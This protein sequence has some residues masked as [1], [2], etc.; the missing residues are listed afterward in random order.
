MNRK[1]SIFEQISMN[2]RQLELMLNIR[3]KGRDEQERQYL[4]SGLYGNNAVSKATIGIYK[5]YERKHI[6]SWTKL[7]CPR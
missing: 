3:R 7:M 6:N 2:H 5:M 1:T 4:F